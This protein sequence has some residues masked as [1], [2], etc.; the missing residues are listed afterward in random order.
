MIFEEVFSLTKLARLDLSFNNLVKISPRVGELTNLQQLWL[1]DN[2][3]REIPLE[4][5]QCRKLRELD[6][7]NTYVITLPR[8]IANLG[9]MIYINMDN[10]PLKDSLATTYGS[11][12]ATVHQFFQRKETR[13]IFKVRTLEIK[14]R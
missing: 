14:R 5:S 8:E 13:A 10:C 1:N 4:V 7:K 11:G 3:L 2:P 6:L 9:N 12:I